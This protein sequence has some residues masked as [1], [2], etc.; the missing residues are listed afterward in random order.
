M[1]RQSKQSKAVRTKSRGAFLCEPSRTLLALLATGGT[2][3]HDAGIAGEG[4]GE[5]SLPCLP[6][7]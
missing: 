5:R 6:T 1:A 3:P 7:L 4:A 2:T